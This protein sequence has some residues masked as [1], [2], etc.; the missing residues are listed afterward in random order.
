VKPRSKLITVIAVLVAALGLGGAALR[1][2]TAAPASAPV[3]TRSTQ[4]APQAARHV[5]ALKM[6]AFGDSV[7]SGTN[8][9]CSPFPVLYADKVGAHT[10]RTTTMKNF[11]FPG[12]TTSDVTG[13]LR[14]SDA[15]AAVRQ[16]RTVLIMIG[17]N[18]FGGAFNDV[19]A[20][21][22]TAAA[23]AP[24]ARSVQTAVT[25]Q[26]AQIERMNPDADVVVG[27]YWNVMKDGSVGMRTYGA[28]GEA[29]ADEA[30]ADANAALRH[31]ADATNATY[32]ST[33]EPFRG[34]AGRRDPTNLLA[35]D[36]D[37]PNAAGHEAIADAFYRAASRG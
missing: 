2:A 24:V 21:R 31:A 26:I 13:Q 3:T 36:G 15:Q 7:A 27:G 16:S 1:S 25:A 37:H 5:P 23:F 10:G 14:T 28:W 6:V 17:A 9:S 30:T 19:L 4:S 32:V 18:D 20:G 8:C 12:A 34:T 35:S 29:Q 33:F 22:Q 11:A